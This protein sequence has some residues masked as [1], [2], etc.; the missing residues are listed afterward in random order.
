PIQNQAGEA[1]YGRL[2]RNLHEVYSLA[3]QRYQENLGLGIDPGL[4][5]DCLPVGIYS[6]CWVSCNPRSLMAFLSLRTNNADA[7]FPSYPLHEIEEAA[8]ACE[9][10][11]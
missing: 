3:Y 6:S 1:A 4:A 9:E 8:K 5:R 2:C 10:V 7:K 11:F